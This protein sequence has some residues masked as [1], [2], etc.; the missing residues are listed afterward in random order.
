LTVASF[1]V[2]RS[3]DVEFGDFDEPVILGG[4]GDGPRDFD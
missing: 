3:G 1:P 2:S 4:F